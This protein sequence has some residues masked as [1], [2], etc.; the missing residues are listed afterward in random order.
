[1]LADANSYR[2]GTSSNEGRKYLFSIVLGRFVMWRSTA[3]GLFC[4]LTP[5]S[6]TAQAIAT[7][8]TT[9]GYLKC[10]FPFGL[11]ERWMMLFWRVGLMVLHIISLLNYLFWDYG[12][13]D[14]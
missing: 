3:V 5:Q 1:M 12:P 11:W 14:L 9:Q 10:C 4:I 6:G 7:E 8:A 2:S 13:V